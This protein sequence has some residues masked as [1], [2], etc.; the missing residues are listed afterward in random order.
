M[1]TDRMRHEQL[2]QQRLEELRKRRGK[3]RQESEVVPVIHDGDL[4]TL[5]V[6]FRFSLQ[7]G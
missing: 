5:Q 3:G 4:T 6:I 1:K 2:A 7:L